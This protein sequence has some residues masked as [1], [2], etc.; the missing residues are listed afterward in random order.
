MH[1][2]IL[3]ASSKVPPLAFI[4][5]DSPQSGSLLNHRNKRR[6]H[7]SLFQPEPA[8][9]S[10]FD[11]VD[12]GKKMSS[13]CAAEPMSDIKDSAGLRAVSDLKRPAVASENE[14][15]FIA[16]P[17]MVGD[18][19]LQRE[20]GQDIAVI[21]DERLIAQEVLHILDAAASLQ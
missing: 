15:D 16:G 6:D 17:E 11:N 3:F 2:Q 12:A 13:D 9:E 1:L 8:K 19:R 14:G 21:N 18:C 10:R 20:S 4:K 7:R 5:N